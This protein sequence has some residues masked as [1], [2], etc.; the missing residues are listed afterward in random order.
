MSWI[1]E[2]ELLEGWENQFGK[3]K[4]LTSAAIGRTH[5]MTQSL[6]LKKSCQKAT[7]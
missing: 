5:L 7:F 6:N 3:E 4:G 1:H 2:G